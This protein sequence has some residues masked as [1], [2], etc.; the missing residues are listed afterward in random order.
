MASGRPGAPMRH[1]SL[2]VILNLIRTAEATTRLEME[3]V[4]GL[5]RATVAD[6]LATLIKLGLVD[7]S[8]LGP[9]GAAGH[10][11]TPD[12]AIRPAFF[13]WPFSVSRRSESPFPI[14]PGVSLSNTMKRRTR[15]PVLL[16]L[17]K[18]CGRCS[19]GGS[20]SIAKGAPSGASASRWAGPVVPAEGQPFTSS[21]LPFMPKWEG[22]PFVEEL[23][24][25]YEAPVWVRSNTQMM[26]L[27]EL[28]A[29]SGV[30]ARDMLFVDLG[31]EISAGIVCDGR[32]YRG[33][34]GGAGLIG[35][36]ATGEHNVTV[37]KCGNT[38]CLEAVTGS[39]AITRT[40]LQ[41]VHSGQSHYLAEIFA[42]S[43]EITAVDVGTA[44]I[45]GDAFCAELL[46]RCGRLIGS[47]L[48]ALANSFNPSLIILGGALAQNSDIL[49]AAIREAVYRRSHPLVTRDLRIVRSQMDSSSALAGSAFSVVDD[50]FALHA[51][52]AWISY[53]SPLRHPDVVDCIAQAKHIA[54]STHERPPP[55]LLRLSEA[56]AAAARNE[57][58]NVAVVL[59]TT[60]SDWAKQQ[61]AGIVATLGAHAAAVV[62]VV[63]CNFGIDRQNQ[64]LDR[65]VRDRP[66]AII[67][68][69]IGNMAVAD[70]HREVQRAGVKLILLDN[71]PTGL[72][73]GQDY[74]AVISA[75]NFGL[76]Q[77]GAKLLAAH[78]AEGGIIGVLTYGVDFFA[79]N[80][81]Y[82]AFRK[83]MEAERADIAIKE[84][85]FA[86]VGQAASA[87]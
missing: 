33:A 4:S 19:I 81:R 24:A 84:T 70:A 76:G 6:R 42:A 29:G 78:I 45:V 68:I 14:S 38:G 52:G 25:H 15:P 9:A 79:T 67:S 65:L 46:S 60:A 47:T 10:H 87:T 26:T 63:D 57:R 58:Y 53:G 80:E 28:R 27:G 40:A 41:A 74:V 69:P 35:H 77:V 73:P 59:H 21:G 49:L 72:L 39:D 37:C 1:Q 50:I 7:E 11:A 34:Q 51:L 61:L 12:S 2:A 36:I 20:T 66:D 44:A 48:A 30:G 83:C 3:R 55:S 85:R 43:G 71:A 32:L 8:E 54:V 75:D 23:V 22:V 82:I 86:E 16:P 5:G 18:G 17:S 64:A 62:E 31:R 13:W 56:E